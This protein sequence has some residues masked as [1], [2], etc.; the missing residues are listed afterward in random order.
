MGACEGVFPDSGAGE[1][2]FAF[3]EVG[4]SRCFHQ[5][6]DHVIVAVV[7]D[8]DFSELWLE[9]ERVDQPEDGWAAI[10]AWS[11]CCRPGVTHT[12]RASGRRGKVSNMQAMNQLRFAG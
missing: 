5:G 12:C 7:V 3:G 4:R 2:D 6:V 9:A 1:L 8:E 11:V 10:L